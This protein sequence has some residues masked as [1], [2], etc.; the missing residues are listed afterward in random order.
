MLIGIEAGCMFCP[1]MFDSG[2]KEF[3]E[4]SGNVIDVSK[5]SVELSSALL[6]MV[7]A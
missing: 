4:E 2:G 1:S 7:H 5:H 3:E 6:P